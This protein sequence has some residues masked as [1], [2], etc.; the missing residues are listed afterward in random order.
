MS[1]K[2]KLIFGAAGVVVIAALVGLNASRSDGATAVRLETVGRR[3][4]VATVTA[5]GQ[6]EPTRKVDI[7]SDI[8]GRIIELPVD[9]GDWVERGDLLVRIDP[10]QYEAGV[11]RAQAA[12]SSAQ[13]SALQARANR[14]QAKRELDRSRTLRQTDSTLVSQV[15]LEQAETNYEVSAAIATSAEHQVEQAR[16]GL[17]EAQEQLAKTILR[18]PMTGQVTRLAVEEGEVAVPGT[19]SRE[20]GLLLTVSDLSV[21][22]VDV[23]VDETDVVRL[24]LGDSTDI[25]IDAYPDTVFGGRVTKIAQSAVRT[26][27]AGATTGDQAVDYDVEI[28][29]DN[30]PPDIRPDLSATARIVTA[31]R[32]SALSIPIIALTVREHKP[33]STENAPADTTT[34]ETEGVFVVVDGV[35]QFRPVTVGIA[36]EEHFEVL[37]G[38]AVGDTIVAGPYQT[39]RDLSDSTRV[40]AMPGSP[41]LE[42]TSDADE[43]TTESGSQQ[44][45]TEPANDTLGEFGS[46]L[47]PPVAAG[48]SL[49]YSVQVAALA[50]LESALE[51]AS[52]FESAGPATVSAIIRGEDRILYRVMVGA[53]PSSTE[54]SA[55]RMELRTQGLLT[56]A[57]GIVVRTPHALE[58]GRQPDRRAGARAVRDLWAAGIPAYMLD[59]PDGSVL[60]VTGAF[61]TPEQA[62]LTRSILPASEETDSVVSRFGVPNVS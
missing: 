28:T 52:Q 30:P 22:Q 4:L 24:H 23:R 45:A 50:G 29:L 25:E 21:I 59:Q 1:G 51:H 16:A 35:A 12:L 46:N 40:R 48:D 57:D 43:T 17:Q 41:I 15:Q 26:A 39:I 7:S 18:S 20:T 13:A 49:F 14:D 10:S 60:L 6:I 36:G 33:I 8:T 53:L 62:Q 58:V 54:A 31:T 55:L 11:A 44:S 38:L 27:A 61:E 19:F 3:S 56:G 5:S 37:A 47:E 42:A 2:K 9:E 34:A 32:D